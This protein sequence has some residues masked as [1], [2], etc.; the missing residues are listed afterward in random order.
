ML[1]PYCSQWATVG[2]GGGG[3]LQGD[4]GHKTQN[5]KRKTQNAKRLCFLSGLFSCFLAAAA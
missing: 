3:G 5:A 4:I 1:V 2:V